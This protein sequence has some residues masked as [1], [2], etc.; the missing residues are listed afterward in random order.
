MRSTVYVPDPEPGFPDNQFLI[1]EIKSFEFWKTV[2]INVVERP[3]I[4]L[5]KWSWVFAIHLPQSCKEALS[6]NAIPM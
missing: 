6:V 2:E 4:S 1:Y 5:K 3:H